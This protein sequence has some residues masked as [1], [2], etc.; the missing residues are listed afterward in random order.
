[1]G[2]RP[3]FAVHDDR[4]GVDQ[5]RGGGTGADRGVLGHEPVE[6]LTARFLRDD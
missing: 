2:A 3:H 6:P 1:V 5:T 4:S